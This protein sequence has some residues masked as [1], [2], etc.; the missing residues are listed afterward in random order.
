[1][2]ALLIIVAA[3]IPFENT[4][5]LQIDRQNIL[6]EHFFSAIDSACMGQRMDN[7]TIYEACNWKLVPDFAIE[8]LHGI[9]NRMRFDSVQHGNFVLEYLPSTVER[10]SIHNCKQT[11]QLQTRMLPREMRCISVSKNLIFGTIDLQRL[12]PRMH[13]LDVSQN[14]ISGPI[15]QRD[16][17]DTLR[18]V[19]IYHNKIQQDVLY[20]EYLPE[21]LLMVSLGQNSIRLIRPVDGM[22]RRNIFYGDRGMLRLE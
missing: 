1:M 6:L 19:L 3:E 11:Y 12:P 4:H 16:L 2:H 5:K 17:P 14:N 20:Y 13:T 15:V 21:T 8:C 22:R 10:T 7:Q 9:V 18:N